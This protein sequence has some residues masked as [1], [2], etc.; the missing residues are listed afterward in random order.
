MKFKL[1]VEQDNDGNF[2]AVCP[3]ISGCISQGKSKDEAIKNIHNAIKGFM[4]YARTYSKPF[5]PKNDENIDTVK[6]FSSDEIINL[7][8]MIG[9]EIDQK[10]AGHTFI[11]QRAFPHRTISIPEYNKISKSTLKNIIQQSGLSIQE[12]K[13]LL[14]KIS[15]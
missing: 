10:I 14:R 4:K 5:P 1:I 7:Y 6:N 2:V 13:D 8:K 3:M 9:Y 15:K 11:R 12:F